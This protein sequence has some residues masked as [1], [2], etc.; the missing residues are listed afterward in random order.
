[1]K[2]DCILSLAILHFVCIPFRSAYTFFCADQWSTVLTDYPK[3]KSTE[4]IR[5]LAERW[6]VCTDREKYEDQAADDKKRFEN[7]SLSLP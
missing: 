2:F 7:V 5:E 1:M 3:Y 4:V 6:A